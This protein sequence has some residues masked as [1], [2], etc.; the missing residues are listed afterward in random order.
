MIDSVEQ[1]EDLLRTTQ[2]I[3]DTTPTSTLRRWRNELVEASVAVSYA[4]SI[5]GLDLSL[6]DRAAVSTRDD[7]L[8]DL[9]NELPQILGDEWVGGGWSLSPDASASVG[10]ASLLTDQDAELYALHAAVAG[11]DFTDPEVVREL[12]ERV[13]PQHVRLHQLRSQ[14]VSR[15]REVQDAVRRQY[16]CGVASVDDWLT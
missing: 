14:L 12:R 3:T 8:Q 7:I 16:A 1:I 10:A 15:L 4:I 13:D 9:V 5:L 2:S 11:C 6:L